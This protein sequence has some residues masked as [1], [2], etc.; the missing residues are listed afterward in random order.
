MDEEILLI[1]LPIKDC[2]LTVSLHEIEAIFGACVNKIKKII[3][4]GQTYP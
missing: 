1:I 2:S 3:A 4:Q